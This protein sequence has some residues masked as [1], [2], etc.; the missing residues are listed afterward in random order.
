VQGAVAAYN[1]S[2]WFNSV[3]YN[4]YC[5]IDQQYLQTWEK[6]TLGLLLCSLLLM[7]GSMIWAL[8]TCIILCCCR[9]KLMWPLP[10]MCGLAFLCALCG[11]IV[12]GAMNPGSGS[13]VFNQGMQAFS[14][15]VEGVSSQLGKS[16][17]VTAIGMAI[18]LANTLIAC[19]LSKM[20]YGE[21]EAEKEG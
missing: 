14:Q 20:H 2:S 7:I 8:F 11:V 17:I 1:G 18:L 13:I 3:K 6:A 21:V 16:F 9:P 5:Q 10:I 15:S 4:S 12:Y 19:C